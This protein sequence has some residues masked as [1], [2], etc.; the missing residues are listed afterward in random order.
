MRLRPSSTSCPTP[1]R[2]RAAFPAARPG[3]APAEIVTIGRMG[4]A[5]DGVAARPGAEP[6]HVPR[7]LPGETVRVQPLQG[8]RRVELLGVLQA[9]PDRVAPPCPHFMQGCGGCAVQ[10]WSDDAYAAWK[11]G[12]V[13]DALLRAGLD[14]DCVGPLVRTPPRSRRRMEFAVE[15][16]DGGVVLG[17]HRAHDRRVLDLS[18]CEVLHPA[19]FALVQPLRSALCGLAALRRRGSVLANLTRSGPDLTMR[20]DGMPAPSDRGK[21]AAFAAAR[22]V[23]RIACALG[24]GQAETAC[25]QQVPMAVFAGH[26]VALPPGAFLQASA[27][28]EAAIVAAV[29]AGLPDRMTGRSRAV[30]L[31][32]GCGTISFPV[33]QR[34]RVQAFEGD[35]Q[36]AAALRRAQAGSRVEA[37]H[38]DLARQ[39]LSA[40]ELSGAAVVILDPPYAGAAMQ[41]PQI[42]RS[43]VGRVVYVS[44][45]PAILARDAALLA[46]AGFRLIRATPIDQFVWSAQ[47]ECVAVFARP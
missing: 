36:A 3:A 24:D 41:V 22:G 23:P 29:L 6:L 2:A 7:S 37:T 11:R 25:Q 30:E 45:N 43:D 18:A 5:G 13:V 4:S 33:A 28:G 27:E 9:S 32:A 17:L 1:D 16:V 38:R 42:A 8:G 20:L 31:Y 46:Q 21:L 47:I 44:C 40:K 35:A 15:R 39:P 26:Q 10:H 12:L 14:A 34:L 19:L